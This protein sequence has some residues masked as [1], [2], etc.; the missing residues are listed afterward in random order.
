MIGQVV[1][2]D[3]VSQTMLVTLA[4]QAQTVKV[5]YNGPPPAPL[6]YVNVVPTGGRWAEQ[7][8]LYHSQIVV[9]ED[10]TRAEDETSSGL[11]VAGDAGDWLF[12]Y[13]ADAATVE[14]DTLFQQ[15]FHG[16]RSHVW[17]FDPLVKANTVARTIGGTTGAWIWT[18]PD[19]LLGCQSFRIV[20]I[21]AGGGAGSGRSGAGSPGGGGPGA[22]GSY[23]EVTL[24]ASDLVAGTVYLIQ[25]GGGGKGG[26]GVAATSNGNAGSAGTADS[27]FGATIADPW[28]IGKVGGG[29]GLGVDAAPG[30][31]GVAGVVGIWPG[32][33]GGSPGVMTAGG[34]AGGS[35][36]GTA[37]AAGNVPTYRLGATAPAGGATGVHDGTDGTA[38][39][40]GTFLSSPAGGTGG[41]G[42]G[43]N[44]GA[45]SGNGGRSA[46]GS[47][48][49]GSGGCTSGTSGDGGNGGDGLVVII[50]WG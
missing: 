10:W 40:E 39:G 18:V 44:A 13:L 19:A 35:G 7:Q 14:Q 11:G 25:V 38:P 20:C 30:G 27:V 36:A 21:G 47:G 45:G 17:A 31:N 23:S 28:V 9:H 8:R 29:G 50:G 22:S 2:I 15:V 6:T 34:G 4:G 5:P 3:R 41:A 37:G 26:A 16:A 48:G 1:S 43:G 12:R 46:L 42:A 49:G 32:A 24:A 33:A